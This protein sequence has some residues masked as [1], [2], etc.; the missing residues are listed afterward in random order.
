MRSVILIT[1]V[2]FLDNTL[3]SGL[4][5][6]VIDQSSWTLSPLNILFLLGVRNYMLGTYVRNPAIHG[7]CMVTVFNLVRQ[8]LCKTSTKPRTR[9]WIRNLAGLENESSMPSSSIPPNILRVKGSS[10]WNLQHYIF[11]DLFD[12]HIPQDKQ[13]SWNLPVGMLN[14]ASTTKQTT[15]KCKPEHGLLQI[16]RTLLCSATAGLKDRPYAR[17]EPQWKWILQTLPCI[18]KQRRDEEQLDQEDILGKQNSHWMKTDICR[19]KGTLFHI[20]IADPHD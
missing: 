16:S 20:V 17:K 18:F 3:K 4:N 7:P 19:H 10:C 2:C 11:S 12:H 15:R 8:N 14:N 6:T 5:N 9:K 1:W 13:I